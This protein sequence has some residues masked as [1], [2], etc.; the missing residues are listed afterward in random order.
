CVDMFSNS[1][2]FHTFAATFVGLL[3]IVFANRIITQDDREIETPSIRTA[4]MKQ[5]SF[6]TI[7]LTAIYNFI[8]LMLV[9]FDMSEI[10]H[11]L[12]LTLVNTLITYVI[13]LMLQVLFTRKRDL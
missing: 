10:F 2:G 9:S 5:F 1:L 8:Y 12:F 11:V 4:D 7:I 3:R 6:Y 13:I